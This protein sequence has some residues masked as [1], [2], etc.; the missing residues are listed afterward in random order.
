MTTLKN[1]WSLAKVISGGQTGADQGGLLAAREFGILTGGV[2]PW[3]FQTSTGPNPLLRAFGLVDMGDYKSRTYYNINN[4]DGTIVITHRHD[5]PGS[6]LTRS[7]CAELKKPFIN[8]DVSKILNL[9]SNDRLELVTR[10]GF[11]LAEFVREFEIQTL[12]VA[13]N[14]EVSD[15]KNPFK[16]T[17]VSFEILVAAFHNL[18]FDGLITKDTDIFQG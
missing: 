18:D 10:K 3:N 12:N 15:S 11:Q 7:I 4:S 16:M 1:K 13:G 2:A 17:D 5:S 14:R 8:I 6:V 9:N